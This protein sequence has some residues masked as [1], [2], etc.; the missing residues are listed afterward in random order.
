[1]KDASHPINVTNVQASPSRSD[2]TPSAIAIHTAP[3][4]MKVRN[5]QASPARGDGLRARRSAGQP[6]AKNAAAVPRTSHEATTTLAFYT[7]PYAGRQRGLGECSQM[8]LDGH[9]AFRWPR[10]EV[11]DVRRR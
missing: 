3:G 10:L 6:S 11:R 7:Q 2:V 5:P 4:A 9:C 1:M 8:T